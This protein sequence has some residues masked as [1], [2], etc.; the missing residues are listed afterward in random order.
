[1]DKKEIKRLIL[2][3]QIKTFQ[4]LCQH[5]TKKELAE[6]M[7]CSVKH[8]NYLLAHPEKALLRDIAG[9]TE[10]LGYKRWETVGKL[11]MFD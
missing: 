1:M 10:W 4:D 6:V 5:V 11:F 9:L 2:S 8:V 3:G 7:G